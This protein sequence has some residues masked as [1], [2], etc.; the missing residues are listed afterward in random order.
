MDKEYKYHAQVHLIFMSS[1][2]FNFA[3]LDPSA[4]PMS[5]IAI[6]VWIIRNQDV[7]LTQHYNHDQGLNW[8]FPK[9]IEDLQLRFDQT[10]SVQRQDYNQVLVLCDQQ[11]SFVNFDSND[12]YLC[13]N[14][15]H[16]THL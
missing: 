13:K 11:F 12:M 10:I 3:L 8:Q 2:A 14:T 7:I 5:N 6:D 16:L 9:F 1:A 15:T 4:L